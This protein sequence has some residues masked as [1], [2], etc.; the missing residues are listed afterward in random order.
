MKQY[1]GATRDSATQLNCG[2]CMW[3]RQAL[4]RVIKLKLFSKASC[5]KITSEFRWMFNGESFRIMK[6]PLP[7]WFTSRKSPFNVQSYNPRFCLEYNVQSLR[8]SKFCSV[9]YNTATLLFKPVRIMCLYIQKYINSYHGGG[10]IHFKTDIPNL[11]TTLLSIVKNSCCKLTTI[12]KQRVHKVMTHF[13]I[14]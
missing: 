3:L 11:G 1:D 12:Y 4:S 13:L 2:T 7:E 5:Q 8:A 9:W 10:Q 14:T 6:R